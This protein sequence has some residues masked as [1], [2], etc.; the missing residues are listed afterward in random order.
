M[1]KLLLSLVAALPLAIASTPVVPKVAVLE[2]PLIRQSTDYSC[3]AAA[4]LAVFAYYGNLDYDESQL[5]K[6]LRTDDVNGTDERDMVRVS[7]KH[8]IP[9]TFKLNQTLDDLRAS[10][11]QKNPVIVDVQAWPEKPHKIPLT[12]VWTD[13]HFVVAVG[14]DDANIYFMDPSHLGSRGYWP[15]RE[16][17]DRW[18]DVNRDGVKMHHPAVY[19][20]ATPMPPD[21]WLPTP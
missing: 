10:L 5:M 11:A 20:D 19:F 8:G 18:H 7:K 6:L 9:A 2:V 15:L 3:G 12:D 1:K 4:M 16:F 17:E 14:M 21:A 13:G